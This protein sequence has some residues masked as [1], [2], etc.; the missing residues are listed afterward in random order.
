MEVHVLNWVA[1]CEFL[2]SQISSL[3]S[4]NPM[5]VEDY[6]DAFEEV[7]TSLLEYIVN[8]RDGAVRYILFRVH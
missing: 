7:S 3:S 1:K 8:M 6:L 5:T 2:L 4:A